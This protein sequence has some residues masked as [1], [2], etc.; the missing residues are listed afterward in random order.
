MEE[1]PIKK[2]D[3]KTYEFDGMYLVENAYDE[4]EL[5]YHDLEESTM[6]GYL[7]NLLGQEPK[8]GDKAEDE[9]CTYTVLKIDNMRITRVKVEVKEKSAAESA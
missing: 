4:M 1:E 2:I 9:Y 5:P 6:G 8:I 7:F 3:A